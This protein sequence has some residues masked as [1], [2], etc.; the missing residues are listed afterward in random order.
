MPSK[1]SECLF[2]IFVIYCLAGI[3]SLAALTLVSSSGIRRSFGSA[4]DP[5]SLICSIPSSVK[6]V[7]LISG[8]ELILPFTTKNLRI[9]FRTFCF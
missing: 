2:S 8:G 3:F 1:T 6:V 4:K 5:S 9:E 7:L